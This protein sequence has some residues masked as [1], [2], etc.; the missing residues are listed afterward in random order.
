MEGHLCWMGQRLWTSQ[1]LKRLERCTQRRTDASQ[2]PARIPWSTQD[3]HNVV[4]CFGRLDVHHVRFCML[5]QLSYLLPFFER[6]AFSSM[7]DVE[8]EIEPLEIVES[9]AQ[10]VSGGFT[11]RG[12]FL[13]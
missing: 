6:D 2:G 10:T 7:G 13:E 4:D 8:S 5:G 11:V 3:V 1:R 12:N 9:C